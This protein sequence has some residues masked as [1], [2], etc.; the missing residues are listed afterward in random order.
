MI[1]IM[2]SDLD[3]GD[4]S[5]EDGAEVPGSSEGREGRDG[6]GQRADDDVRQRHVAD[7]HVGPGLQGAAP[8]N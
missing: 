2:I 7:V 1:L 4:E 3:K 8:R 6:G 5:A